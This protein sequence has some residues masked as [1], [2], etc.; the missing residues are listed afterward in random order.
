MKYAITY[1]LDDTWQ[2]VDTLLVESDNN[3]LDMPHEEIADIFEAYGIEAERAKELAKDEEYW[4][5][6]N[7]EDVDVDNTK[8]EQ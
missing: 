7:A 4:F 5:V 1:A 2:S 8:G 6:R 3:P